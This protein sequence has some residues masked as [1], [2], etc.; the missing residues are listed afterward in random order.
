[1]NWQQWKS[2]LVAPIGKTVAVNTGGY[3]FP[4]TFYFRPDMALYCVGPYG[5]IYEYDAIET[6]SWSETEPVAEM[7]MVKPHGIFCAHWW[8]EIGHLL[9]II[10]ENEI[11][12]FCELGILDGGLSALL[13]DRAR[14]F[15][16]FYYLGVNL[17]LQYTDPRVFALS[18]A[19][20]DRTVLADM[21]LWTARAVAAVSNFIRQ[22]EGRAF[23]YCDG[24]NKPREAALYWPILRP[25]D[26]LGVHDYS[27]DPDAKGPEVYPADVS[28]ILWQGKRRGQ[29]ALADTRILLVEKV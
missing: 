14:M 21:D 1:M 3:I 11:Q 28:D 17:G 8:N 7:L 15:S 20:P 26:L 6:W 22:H 5:K 9:N 18:N 12:T 16:E 13:L 10:Q 23:I 24:G 4:G 2:L 27:D 29:E 19:N 25:G